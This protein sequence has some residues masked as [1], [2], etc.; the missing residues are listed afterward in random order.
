MPKGITPR[1]ARTCSKK[2]GGER[3]TCLPTYQ[4][5]AWAPGTGRRGATKTFPRIG[6]AE[7]WLAEKKLEIRRGS[8]RPGRQVTL[9]VAFDEL[10]A[11]MRAGIVRNRSGETYKPGVIREYERD[12]RN[13]ILPLFGSAKPG[14]IRGADVQR[15]VGRLVRDGKEASTVHNVMLPLRVLYRRLIRLEDLATSPMTDLELPAV[16]GKRLRI[17]P[18]EEAA[19][20][21]AAVPE[22]ERAIWAI[23]MYGG[24]R[25]GEIQA[26]DV[27]DVDL[28]T[29]VINVEFN[30][31]RIEGKVRPKSAAGV[32]TVPVAGVLRQHLLDHRLAGAPTRGLLFGRA[33][34]N[35]FRADTVQRRATAA[36]KAENDRRV[37]AAEEGS[38]PVLLRRLTFHDC[39]HTYAS[40]MI[41]AMAESPEGFNPKLLSTYMG[42]ST[43]AITIDRYG[44]LFPGS[45]KKS[46]GALDA[47][48]ERSDT[49]ARKDAMSDV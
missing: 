28:A 31:D 3:C 30:W 32:R 12:A 1:H 16:R 11:D 47:F 27:N 18:P 46:A 40:L 7:D 29:G 26:L 49:A 25:I 19:V 33:V 13:H 22:P 34:D 48:L 24:L 36:W 39:R 35:A 9:R 38:E 20:L 8:F 17:A 45:E 15:L 4:A 43:I 42:H 23:A 21:I 44:H 41:A 14:D 37:E 5:Q 6:E 2:N 10:F